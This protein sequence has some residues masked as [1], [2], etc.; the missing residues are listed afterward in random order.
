MTPQDPV[1]DPAPPRVRPAVPPGARD[2][3]RAAAATNI[4][5]P[6]P[7]PVPMSV[8]VP[9]PT[10]RETATVAPQ[11]DGERRRSPRQTLVARAAL[12]SECDPD[13]VAAG[14]LSNISVLGVGLHTRRP[15]AVGET[16]RMRLDLGPMKWATRLRVV[17]CRPHDSGT[18][19][20]G[21]Q[22]VG[23]ALVDE[24]QRELAA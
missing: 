14:F 1:P 9:V 19:D 17:T 20:V 7:M 6:M 4:P 23:D 16:F 11:R 10:V 2:D 8:P 24:V 5:M 22:F 3:A 13:T 18:Y 12:Q 21:A 15:L